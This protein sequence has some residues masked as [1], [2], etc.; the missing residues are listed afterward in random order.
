MNLY[1]DNYKYFFYYI[2]N[3]IILS[4]CQMQSCVVWIPG[5]LLIF[6][7]TDASTILRGLPDSFFIQI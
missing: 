1:K 6:F 3:S 7:F 4:A 2:I 5:N